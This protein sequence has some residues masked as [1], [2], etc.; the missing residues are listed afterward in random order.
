MIPPGGS[1]GIGGVS[2]AGGLSGAAS[3]PGGGTTTG[4]GSGRGSTAPGSGGTSSAAAPN[5]P[6]YDDD[7]LPDVHTPV[8]SHCHDADQK[9]LPD[10]GQYSQALAACSKIGSFV[11]SGD[12]PP[13]SSG[14]SLDA[15][16][17][18]MVAAWVKLGCPETAN[19][20]PAS[21]R[22]STMPMGAGGGTGAGGASGAGTGAGGG[23]GTGAGGGTG[24]GAGTGG[25][26][27]A[28]AGGGASAVMVAITRA[29]W[30]SEKETL[31]LEGT[32]S[33]YMSTMNA[34]FGGRTEGLANSMGRFR[35]QFS[36]VI[37]NPGTVTVKTNDG[38]QATSTV[39]AK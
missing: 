18:A 15:A 32:C 29:E 23:T 38:A 30:D 16:Q 10:W 20:L 26:A 14:L 9:K 11:A 33:N 24:T 31:R 7:F 27:G 37:V 25:V 34:E 21:C 3:T 13:P 4:P 19:D 12:M 17:K 8:C 2:G 28:G 1:G 36:N 6:T 35:D 22:P 39:M 5:C